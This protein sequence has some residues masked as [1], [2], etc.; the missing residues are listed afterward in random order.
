MLSYLL[1]FYCVFLALYITPSIAVTTASCTVNTDCGSNGT[2]DTSTNTC[3]CSIGYAT[4][5]SDKPCAYQQK[6]KLVAFFVSF[7][8]GFTGADWFYLSAGNGGYIA[9][10]VFKLLTLG[11]IGV[12]QVV[13]WIRIL[14]DS[15]LDGQG[16]SLKDWD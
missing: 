11:G 14:D 16:V 8:A 7:F 15:F 9:A 5:A 2:C 3:N 13:D 1:G 6:R 10:G 12:W 4:V